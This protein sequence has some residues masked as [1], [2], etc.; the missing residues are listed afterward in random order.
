MQT[1]A[2]VILA[3]IERHGADVRIVYSERPWVMPLGATP[4]GLFDVKPDRSP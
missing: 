3:F 2:G 1:E 4:S